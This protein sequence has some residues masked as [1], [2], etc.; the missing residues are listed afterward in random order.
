MGLSDADDDMEDLPEEVILASYMKYQDTT[1]LANLESIQRGETH[2]RLVRVS[3]PTPHMGE[4]LIQAI[5]IANSLEEFP[6]YDRVQEV[7]YSIPESTEYFTYVS[8]TEYGDEI[9]ILVVTE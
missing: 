5:T 4:D 8:F 9:C 3:Q 2:M 6:S 7:L 1:N